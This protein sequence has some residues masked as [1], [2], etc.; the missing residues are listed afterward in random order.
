MD[1][2]MAANAECIDNEIAWFRAVL[3]WRFRK[4][5][6]NAPLP[7]AIHPPHPPSPGDERTPYSSVVE[8]FNMGPAERLVLILAYLPHIRPEMLDPFLIQNESLHRRF[9]EFGGLAGASHGGFLPS[10]ETAVF[11]LAGNDTRARLAHLALFHPDHYFFRF[12]ILRNE[13]RDAMAGIPEPT[14]ARP[15]LLTPEFVELLTTGRSY[16][17]PFSGEFPAQR[18]TTSYEWDDLVL[19]NA[20]RRQVEDIVDWV[21]YRRTLLEEWQLA[22]RIK[23]GFRSLFYGPPGTGKS[24]TAALLGKATEMPVF[25]V[26]LSSVISKYIGET[27]KNLASLF[28]H[29]ENRGWILFFDEADS[30]FGKR[31]ETRNSNDR[32][33]NQQVSYLL[34]R[35][36]DFPGIVILASNMKSHIDEAFSRRFQSIIH[37]PMPDYAQRLRLWEDNFKAKP[38]RLADDIN[39]Q[40]LARDNEISGGNIINVLRYACLKAAARG[41]ETIRAEDI[42]QGI[43]DERH[44]EGKFQG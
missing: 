4:H 26:D 16:Y 31:T 20:T 11:L 17:P 38:F 27:E 40:G 7:D 42:Q 10:F 5:A 9:T 25:R 29:A 2:L 39:L 44:K 35:I 14:L 12:Q 18:I 3:D 15:L 13:A 21:R 36:E 6:G 1:R 22:G 33:A 41:S 24:L 34:Q 43:R 28:D 37:F 8:S 30:L 23:P 32:A 19:D